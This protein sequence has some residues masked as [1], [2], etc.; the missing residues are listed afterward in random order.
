ML[1]SNGV[2]PQQIV[3][4]YLQNSPELMFATLACWAIGSAPAYINY[5]LTGDALVHCLKVNGAKIVLVD[6][7]QDQLA[8]IDEVKHRIGSELGMKIIV[9]DDNFKA[10]IGVLAP[11][12][13]G[14]EF[15]SGLSVD[16]PMAL[17]YTRLALPLTSCSFTPC[18]LLSSMP[19]V[20]SSCSHKAPPPEDIFAALDTRLML[21]NF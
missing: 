3:A 2:K 7:D 10:G 9:L 1:Q 12:R 4:I 17:F 8:R 18:R 19:Y 5:N 16:S 21:L 14:D 13:P 20:A 11:E 6:P 15:R